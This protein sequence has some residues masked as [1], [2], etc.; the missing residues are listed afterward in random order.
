MNETILNKILDKHHIPAYRY[1]EVTD[2]TNTQAINWISQGAEEYSLVI[3]DAQTAGRGRSG[4]K[5][6]TTPDASIAVSIIIHPTTE[7]QDRLGLFS[8]LGGYALMATLNNQYGIRSQVKWPND[9]LIDNKKTAGILAETVW[10]GDKLQGLVL[11]IGINIKESSIP[12]TIDLLFPATCIQSHTK[13]EIEAESLLGHLM[14][15]LTYL[16]KTMLMPPFIDQYKSNLA[17]M[18]QLISIDIGDKNLVS[19]VLH[20]I[21]PQGELI[22][23]ESSGNKRTFPIG[24]IKLRPQ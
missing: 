9:V 10:Q 1:F 12:S 2:S 13:K 14:G 21:N 4:R 18:D 6:I 5:W 15:N 7:E 16:R 22:L 17:Y 3:A 20:G 19:G 11:G 24:D 23:I 8:L